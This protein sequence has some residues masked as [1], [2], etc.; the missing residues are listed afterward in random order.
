MPDVTPSDDPSARAVELH[1]RAIALRQAGEFV[2]AE[3]RC[4]EA[5][6]LFATVEGEESPNLANALVEHARLLE[7]IDALPE[8]SIC[9]D[10]A[11]AILQ[12]LAQESS[13]DGVGEEITRLTVHAE[14]VRA[15]GRRTQGQLGEAEQICRRALRL[16]E[17][18]LGPDDLL[19]ADVLNALGVV[20]KFQGRYDEAEPLYRRALALLEAQGDRQGDDVATLLHNLGGLAHARGDFA[21]GEPLARRAVELREMSLGRD[22]PVTAADRAAW[23]ALLEGLGRPEE[24][25]RAYAQALAVF[26]A[27]LGAKSLEVAAALTSLGA[28]RHARGAVAAAEHGY[29]RALAIREVT[30][31]PMHFDVAMTLNNLAMLLAERGAAEATALATRAH[32]IF[33]S[34]LGDTHPHTRAATDNLAA[35]KAKFGGDKGT[36]A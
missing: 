5:V 34:E 32:A 21:A 12:P 10:R 17:T 30:L 6:A 24:A 2:A 18:R 20:H 16:A 15:S 19:V 8:A 33:R 36:R 1:E 31:G 26:E 3:N 23:G 7:L 29:R 13:A 9:I 27:R 35:L 14:L 11:L 4:R 22:H 25:E 28:V